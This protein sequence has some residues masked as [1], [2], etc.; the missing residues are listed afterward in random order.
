MV[1]SRGLE[2]PRVAPLAPQASASTTSATTAAGFLE[3]AKGAA[4]NDGE[5]CNKLVVLGQGWPRT[6]ATLC[7]RALEGRVG[8]HGRSSLDHRSWLRSPSRRRGSPRPD[9]TK[10]SL[11]AVRHCGPIGLW[12]LPLSADREH[13]AAFP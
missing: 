13:G 5:P 12:P 9:H 2:P 8:D 3:P 11:I 10:I 1:R 4:P 7:G 6:Q